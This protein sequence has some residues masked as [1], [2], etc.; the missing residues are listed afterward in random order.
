MSN[1]QLVSLCV[2]DNVTNIT[3][4]TKCKAWTNLTSGNA[5]HKKGW[6][7]FIDK[8]KDNTI[9][10][11]DNIIKT[12]PFDDFNN[13]VGVLAISSIGQSIRFTPRGLLSSQ[14]STITIGSNNPQYSGSGYDREIIIASNTGRIRTEIVK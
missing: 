3:P 1:N 12:Q 10:N 14:G 8:N 4:S 9:G 5:N 7:I 11:L 6:V 13:K 2:T